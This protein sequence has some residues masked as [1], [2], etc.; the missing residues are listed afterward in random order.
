MIMQQLA[1]LLLAPWLLVLVFLYWIWPRSLPRTRGRRLFDIAAVLAATALAATLIHIAQASY[2]AALVDELGRRSGDI[3]PQVLAALYAYAGFVS[4]LGAAML[5]R[6][7]I[8]RT[9]PTATSHR[10]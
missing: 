10:P 1:L 4:V 6:A 9:R 8:W 3:W 7:R 2:V 5:L